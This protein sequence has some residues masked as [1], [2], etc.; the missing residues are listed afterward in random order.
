MMPPVRLTAP[1]PVI[2]LATVRQHLRISGTEED[3]LLAI[4]LKTA[5]GKLD[6]WNG[7]L[8]RC[9]CAQ[10][11]R[12]TAADFNGGQIPLPFAGPVT[13]GSVVYLD[14]DGASQTVP[15]AQCR[16]EETAQGTVLIVDDFAAFDVM[17]DRNDA[18][19]ITAT[20]G[21]DAAD[22]PGPILSAILLLVSHYYENRSAAAFGG[23]FG[24]L[25]MGV[26]D[27]IQPWR[28]VWTAE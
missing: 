11:W 10:D 15:L 5:L 25:P 28:D 27:L 23:G 6:G 8:T 2:D 9:I 7:V 12:S 17:P 24:Q 22:V 13:L 14:P 19:R 21:W 26:L 1:T 18:V 4:Y 3:A 16:I 20:Y